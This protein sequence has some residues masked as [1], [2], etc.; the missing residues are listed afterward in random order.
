MALPICLYVEAMHLQCFSPTR[1]VS[2]HYL[3]KRYGPF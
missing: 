3:E 1:Y 2:V